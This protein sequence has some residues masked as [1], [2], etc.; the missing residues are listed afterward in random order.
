LLFNEFDQIFHDLFLKKGPFYKEIVTLLVDQNLNASQIAERLYRSTGSDLS[1]A[2]DE[3]TQAGFLAR[4]FTWSLKTAKK[5]AVNRYRLRDNYLRFYLKYIFPHKGQIETGELTSLPHGW[6]S[7]LGLQFENLV[8]NNGAALRHCLGISPD[9]V[10]FSNAYLQ[11]QRTRRAG[12]QIDYM[13]QTRFRCLYVFEV[14]FRQNP[15]GREVI[16]EVQQ[17]L[18]ALE[19]PR[20]FSLR[21]VLIHVNGVDESVADSGF[22]ARIIDFSELLI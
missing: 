18:N 11:T 19:L 14:K 17:K 2:L 16:D 20:G 5:L 1:S 15:V 7:I 8:V 6:Y 13:I 21:P 22:F 10:V 4:D 12:C 9:E 3:L